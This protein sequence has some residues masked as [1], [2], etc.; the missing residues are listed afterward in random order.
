VDLVLVRTHG[1]GL[2]G[3]ELCRR[4]RANE[5]TAA[6][7]VVLLATAQSP[8]ENR[9]RALDMGA[10][11]FIVQPI[12][13]L[14]LLARLGSVL[15]SKTLATRSVATILSSPARWWNV[16]TNWKSW[17]ESCAPSAT[18]SATPFN[19]IEDGLFAGRRVG[20]C[21]N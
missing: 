16:P 3:F 5:K 19:V 4:V 9:L 10:A 2:D 21:A 6:V 18:L 8:V 20:T 14:E 11:D 12:E 13:P 17:R 1:Q 7:P 15:R